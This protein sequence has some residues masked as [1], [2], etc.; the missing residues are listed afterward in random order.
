[1]TSASTSAAAI[2]GV[3]LNAAAPAP[4]A[5]TPAPPVTQSAS[6]V[7]ASAAEGKPKAGGQIQPAALTFKKEPEY[8]RIAKQTGA[9]GMVVLVAS[10][11]KDG[12]V[13][14]V[15]VISGHAMLQNSAV[16]AVK[17]WVY[18]PALLNGVPVE[19]DAQITLNFLGDR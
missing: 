13:K 6:P 12:K 9:K 3:N 19:T 14:N 1:M 2:P 7:T 11:G 4:K 17:Q 16:E 5:P 8:P 18:K 10:I 15:K